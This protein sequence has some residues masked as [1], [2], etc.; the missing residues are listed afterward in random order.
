MT[1]FK[2]EEHTGTGRGEITP[3][4]CAVE[5]YAGLKDSGEP[6]VIAAAAGPGARTLLELGAGAGR[7]TGPLVARGFEVT[8]V[9]ES[10]G[11][12]E[13]A[14]ERAPGVRTVLSGIEDLDL[15]ERFDVV[16]LTSFLI[17]TADPEG[18]SRLLLACARHVAADGCVV[19]QRE[20]DH[21]PERRKPGLLRTDESGTVVSVEEVE[22]LGEGVVR[23]VVGYERGG[24][25]WTQTFYSRWLSREDFQHALEQA[26][27]RIDG[28]LTDDGMW[29]RAVPAT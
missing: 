27:L 6:E 7:M 3:D 14:A 10:A 25:R 4:G 9:D 15:G 8:A 21:H 12:L 5:M 11:M 29:A 13:R 22:N 19:L 23:N 16:T 17:N 26:G 18:R 1:A 2:R 24:E 28:Y 20:S